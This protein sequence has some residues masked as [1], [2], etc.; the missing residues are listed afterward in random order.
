MKKPGTHKRLLKLSLAQ[1]SKHRVAIAWLLIL[2]F[3]GAAL[4]A[5]LPWPLKLIIDHVLGDKPLPDI[6]GALQPMFESGNPVPVLL[7]LVIAGLTLHFLTQ[8]IKLIQG[9]VEVGVGQGLTFGLGEEVLFHL[10]RQSLVYHASQKSGD[11][12]RRVTTD[13]R[14]VQELVLGVAVPLLTSLVNLG[15]MFVIMYSLNP[16]M[17]LVA[18]CAAIPIPLLI[19]ALAPRMAEN[20]YQHQQSEGTLMS[21]AEQTLTG[22]PMVQAFGQESRQNDNFR[23]LSES[24]MKCYLAAIKAQLKFSVGVSSSTAAGTAI[25]MVVGGFAVLKNTLTVG[26]LLVFLAYV[27]SLYGPVETLAYLSSVYASAT[28]RAR[29]VVEVLNTDPEVSNATNAS[30]LE[31]SEHGMAVSFENIRFAY[32][33]D[34]WILDGVTLEVK[35]GETMALVGTTGSGKSTLVSLLPRFS[36]PAEGGIRINSTDIRGLTVES[37]RQHISM[38]LQ[39]P[40]LLPV[41]IAEN[42]AYGRPHATHD[43]IVQAAMNANA[44]EFIS[45]LPDG[46]H[47]VLSE[48][49]GDLS[50]GQRQ[51]IAIAR[52]F[53]KDAPILILDEPTSALDARSET[54]FLSALERLMEGRTTMIIAHRLS[55]IQNADVIAVLDSGSVIEQ[56]SHAELLALNG[57]YQKLYTQNFSKMEKAA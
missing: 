19:R 12:V 6:L 9:W 30:P 17:T 56:G 33:P 45:R 44:H 53:L 35:A 20:T 1:A 32:K 25:M 13:T 28:G 37:L 42:I 23:L 46:Y 51:R 48:Q 39:D 34:E 22:L 55:T 49:A 54:L 21:V 7:A 52:A 40:F 36:D 24:T 4:M 14:C 29:R 10:Q 41:T 38:V 15:M 47:T 57:E 16:M 11:L 18:L 5:L 43:E 2:I 3:A 31:V 27:A 26:E 50:G 8:L